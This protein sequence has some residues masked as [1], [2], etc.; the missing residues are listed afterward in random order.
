MPL[1]DL[2]PEHACIQY[3]YYNNGKRPFL[4]LHK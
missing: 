3:C 2:D 1:A 4:Q